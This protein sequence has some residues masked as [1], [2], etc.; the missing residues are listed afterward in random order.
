MLSV[1]SMGCVI[2]RRCCKRQTYSS[3][4]SDS[5]SDAIVPT[6]VKLKLKLNL[7]R[8]IYERPNE[9]YTLFL[10]ASRDVQDHYSL[11]KTVEISRVNK[12][13][14]V[15]FC[16]K[17]YP[18]VPDYLHVWLFVTYSDE[19]K[20]Q[21]QTLLATGFISFVQLLNSLSGCPVDLCDITKTKQAVVH[22]ASHTIHE[23]QTRE[24]KPADHSLAERLIE[25]TNQAYEQT[26]HTHDQRFVYVDTH[27]GRF[28]LI[29]YPILATT[30]KAHPDQAVRL[31][32]H[33]LQL[34]AVMVGV[35][36]SRF[37]SF[38]T[39]LKMELVG[40]MLTLIPRSLIYQQDFV[41]TGVNSN[42]LVDHWTVLSLFPNL[43]AASF[44]CEDAA[45]H[46][47]E[48]FTMLKHTEI[49][50]KKPEDER[51]N[52]RL[53]E[54]QKLVKQYTAFL[55]LGILNLTQGETPHA[56]VVLLD[57]N[58]VNQQL[59]GQG[60]RAKHYLPALAL[61]GTNYTES[62]WSNETKTDSNR[63]KHLT[64][65]VNN[66]D[67]WSRILK[68]KMPRHE[69]QSQ[70]MYGLVSALLTA[71]HLEFR[72]KRIGL[73]LLLGESKQN[74]FTVGVSLDKLLFYES[75]TTQVA[76]KLD[77][78]SLN[79]IISSLLPQFPPTTVPTAPLGCVSVI[80]SLLQPSYVMR[81]IDE[82]HDLT[83][84]VKIRSLK[85]LQEIPLC[86]SGGK[87]ITVLSVVL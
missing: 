32:N 28:P 57:S 77:E 36:L 20:I 54:L 50:S 53:I 76:L 43:G 42:K 23:L 69:V 15:D 3:S 81:K 18:R 73:H 79:E 35:N 51:E 62:V 48:M 59:I 33:F 63:Y 21:C 8:V 4:L 70:H 44:D 30:I 39:A 40:E 65:Q 1:N 22:V 27:V 82:K 24:P 25:Q 75:V 17:C 55:C 38:S 71:D 26:N 9:Q 7:S 6:V 41:R 16:V 47:L 12:P 80:K 14:S 86:V 2:G 83:E 66:S 61:E 5:D 87:R 67:K 37:D 68:L 10:F 11:N 19:D 85:K 29:S 13:Q 74:Q 64:A 72:E 49:P 52:N 78:S 84:G 60:E 31:F 46:M 58:Y 45:K 34:A 56:Y